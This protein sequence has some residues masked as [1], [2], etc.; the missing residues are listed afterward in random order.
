[1]E[2]SSKAQR[3]RV[4]LEP[5]PVE[6]SLADLPMKIIVRETGRVYILRGT[7]QQKI[8]LTGTT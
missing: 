7:Q 2:S 5:R 1:M 3:E 6:V 4:K 8:L